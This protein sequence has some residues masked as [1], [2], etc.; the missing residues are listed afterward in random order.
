MMADIINSYTLLKDLN[1]KKKIVIPEKK[2]VD[3][4]DN[5]VMSHMRLCL[6]SYKENL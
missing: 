4:I 5:N 3:Y 6:Q 2:E 1:S